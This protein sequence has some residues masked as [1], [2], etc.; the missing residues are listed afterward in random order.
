MV[1][2]LQI[3]AP[4]PATKPRKLSQG[5]FCCRVLPFSGLWFV[6]K[7]CTLQMGLLGRDR[8]TACVGRDIWRSPATAPLGGIKS[9]LTAGLF[10]APPAPT[11]THEKPPT[12]QPLLDVLHREQLEGDGYE[13]GVRALGTGKWA[14]KGLS[15]WRKLESLWLR[16]CS[17]PGK[18]VFSLKGTGKDGQL[19]C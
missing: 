19:L 3:K 4:R 5:Q 12:S 10:T 13:S 16:L 8:A 2:P 7:Q 1:L 11:N 14:E 6:L 17:V 15:K 9:P 18:T